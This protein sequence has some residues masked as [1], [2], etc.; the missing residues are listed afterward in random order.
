MVHNFIDFLLSVLCALILYM[1]YRIEKQNAEILEDNID[2][3]QKYKVL[4]AILQGLKNWQKDNKDVHISVFE[5][6]DDNTMRDFK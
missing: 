5:I 2:L 1:N 4:M 3:K 6:D